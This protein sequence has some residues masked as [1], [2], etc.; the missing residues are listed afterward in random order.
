MK[1]SVI[2]CLSSPNYVALQKNL[3]E[4]IAYIEIE[5]NFIFLM[6]LSFTVPVMEHRLAPF[7]PTH[8]N[9]ILQYSQAFEF[10]T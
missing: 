4:N 3:L 6:N 9:N 7:S 2:W 1:L 8:V 5:S 10:Y